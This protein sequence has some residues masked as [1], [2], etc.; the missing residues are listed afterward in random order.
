MRHYE[1][2]VFKPALTSVCAGII[3]AGV[4]YIYSYGIER[5]KPEMVRDF[6]LAWGAWGPLLFI[7]GN[8]VRPFF[9]FPAIVLGIAGGLA[10]GPLWGTLFL[11]TGTILGA[12]LG[13]GVARALGRDTISRLLP[14]RARLAELDEL[15]GRHTFRTVLAL[16]IVPIMPWDAVSF[17]AGISKVRFWPYLGATSLGSLPG[18]VVFSFL[19]GTLRQSLPQIYLVV[20]VGIAAVIYLPAIYLWKVNHH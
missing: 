15:A 11:V 2:A 9:F 4:V 3:V 18:A 16:R 13:F 5:F 1:Q 14:K 10:F 20:V 6:V 8:M 17:L 7:L 19:G 12:V